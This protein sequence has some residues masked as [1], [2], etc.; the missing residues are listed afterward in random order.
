M[1]ASETQAVSTPHLWEVDHSYYCNLSNYY[2]T[3]RDKGCREYGSFADFLAEEGD[4]DMDYNLVFRW[5][6]KEGD[7]DD[8]YGEMPLP[9]T[10]DD[11][12]RNGKLYLFIMQQRKGLYE[13]IEVEVC[14][15]D[16]PAVIAYLAS[17][18]EHMKKLWEPLAVASLPSPIAP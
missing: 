7:P 4:A 10:G 16:E 14:R 5:D 12:Y 13:W 18:W 3:S 11:N 17:R 8:N 6:W 2:A 15:A 9:Y 1:T